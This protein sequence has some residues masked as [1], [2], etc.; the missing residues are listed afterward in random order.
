PISM[1]ISGPAAS[2]GGSRSSSSCCS[3]AC[4]PAGVGSRSR[5]PT[6]PAGAEGTGGHDRRAGR[7]LGVAA[8]RAGPEGGRP[9]AEARP[10][11]LGAEDDRDQLVLDQELPDALPRGEDALPPPADQLGVPDADADQLAAG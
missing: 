10:L 11:P 7:G 5:R 8:A 6:L 1:T 4:R 3:S 9:A 2:S